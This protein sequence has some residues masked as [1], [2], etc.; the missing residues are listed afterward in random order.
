MFQ[1]GN[2]KKK[3][4]STAVVYITYTY[5]GPGLVLYQLQPMSR[6]HMP[7]M[8]V[9]PHIPSKFQ[10]CV[11]IKGNL[12]MGETQ[13]WIY[14]CKVCRAILLSSVLIHQMVRE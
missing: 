12:G 13:D 8:T 10:A 1:K 11:E 7:Y 6:E 4:K 14:V 3:K 5:E 2:E 9:W